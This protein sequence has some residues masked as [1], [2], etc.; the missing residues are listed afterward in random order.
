MLSNQMLSN[1]MRVTATREV[2]VGV[3]LRQAARVLPHHNSSKKNSFQRK[4]DDNV[5]HHTQ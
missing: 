4:S 1:Q 3:L 5:L 2:L